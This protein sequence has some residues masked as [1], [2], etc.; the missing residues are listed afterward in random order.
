LLMHRGRCVTWFRSNRGRV[1]WV[2]LFALASQ[3]VLS[4][5]HI[6][7]GKVSVAPIAAVANLVLA[8][9]AS[10]HSGALPRAPPLND[11]T[12]RDDLC[13]LCASINLAAS[14]VV[15]I[16]PT[17]ASPTFYAARTWSYAGLEPGAFDHVFFDAR[18]PPH[19]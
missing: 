6:H 9:K 14:L 11:S 3:L 15:P 2:A 19:A 12:K 10:E 16:A 8:V 4:F 5:G 13:A 17:V 1:T 18:G 7:L